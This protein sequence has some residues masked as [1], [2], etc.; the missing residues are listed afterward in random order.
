MPRLTLFFILSIGCFAVNGLS[1]CSSSQLAEENSNSATSTAASTSSTQSASPAVSPGTTSPTP[2]QVSPEN[3]PQTSTS[4]TSPTPSSSPAAPQDAGLR[5][6]LTV[7]KLKNSTYYFLAKGP[8][9]LVNG[10]YEDKETKR[11]YSLSDVVAYGDI[12]KDGIKD[13]V[14]ALTIKIPNRGNFSYLV[15]LANDRG[16]AK[17][18]STEFMGPEIRVKSLKVNPDNSIEAV[19]DQYQAGDPECC[20]SLKITKTYKLKINQ[21]PA[22]KPSATKP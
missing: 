13:A 6:P 3:K 20:P 18:I 14:S 11:I 17:N 5:P 8:I 15:A 2:A 16:T 1:G 7:D 4:S 19:M 10:T 12:D 22:A 21:T 9:Q